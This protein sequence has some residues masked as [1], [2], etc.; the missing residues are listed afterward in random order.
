[1]WN[2]ALRTLRYRKTGFIATFIGVLLGSGL[3]IACA[4]LMETGIRIAVPPERFAAVPVVVS[5][6]QAYLVPKEDPNDTKDMKTVALAE[7]Q[8]LDPALADELASVDGVERV[9]GETSVAATVVRDGQP[10]QAGPQSLG[11]GWSSAQLGSYEK[12]VDGAEPTGDRDVVLDEATAG[13]A[14]VRVGDQVDVVTR[15]EPDSF[16]VTGLVR[17][18]QRDPQSLLFFADSAIADLGEHG[19]R[20]AAFGLFVRSGVD[21]DTLQE[22]LEDKLA[23]QPYS[24]LTGDDRGLAEHPE[25]VGGRAQ[26]IP[27]AA[28]FGGMAVFISMFVVSSTLGLSIQQRQKEIASL[29]AIGATPSQVRRMVIGEAFFVAAVAALLGCIPGIVAGPLLFEVISDAGVI[30][31]VV[32]YHQSFIAYLIGPAVALL[33]TLLAAR[34][35]SSRAARVSP[36]EA[37][38]EASVQ[39]HWVTFPRV[40]F[41]V[42]FFLIGIGLFI[43]T[44]VALSGPVASATAGPAVMAWAISLAL[45]SPG[46]TKVLG[47]LFAV[48]VRATGGVVGYLANNNMRL[49]AV[50]M[51][52]AVTPIMLAVGIALANFYT[53]TT[54]EAAAFRWFADDL[55]ADAVVTS[56]TGG[57]TEDVVR[58][59]R[60]V[61]GVEGASRYVTSA[62][63]IDKPYDGSHVESPWP[64]QGVDG[65][66]AKLIT[67]ITPVKGDLGDLTGSTAGLPVETAAE[68]GVDIGDKVTLRLGDREPVEVTLVATY[69]AKEGYETILAPA[70]LLAEH[71]T[72]GLAR[73]VL[74][75]AEAGTS[76]EALTAAVREKVSGVPGAVV[77]DRSAIITFAEGTKTQTWVNYLLVGVITGYTLISV[78]NTLIM[79][80]AARKRELGMQRLIGS[81]PRQVMQ[82]LA[83]EAVVIAGIGVVLGTFAS[84]ATLMPFSLVVLDRPLP[85][86][87]VWIFLAVVAG[88]FA[89]TLAATL[90][91]ARK[92]LRL[93]SAEAARAVE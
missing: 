82:M 18:P 65:E 69:E 22:E 88:A 32:E 8:W 31:P 13:L 7:R 14:G 72:T 59:L 74:V 84:I 61:D 36:V 57:F 53:S 29:R 50:R 23:G 39:R 40:L 34:I 44:G 1:M 6:Q 56:T 25:A 46:L 24:V 45:L 64:M 78:A 55:Q 12:L 17:A 15:G 41:A 5:G 79:A 9:V 86:G 87:P 4:G 75:K 35:T 63:W 90:L 83:L 62:G 10:V 2:L 66:S 93:P 76:A 81:T 20:V 28:V 58:D 3:V 77:G 47:R 67:G 33:T 30:S 71:S 54:Q 38:A 42:L 37:L 49:R 48:P 70:G 60:S 68:M 11:H 80:T 91:P 51:A 89:L 43:V 16:R 73:Q 27:L 92:I 52:A 85:S 26:L 21:V 19:D